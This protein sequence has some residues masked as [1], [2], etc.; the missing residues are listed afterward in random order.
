[1]IIE[2]KKEESPL[3]P[4]LR[5]RLSVACFLT[6]EIATDDLDELSGNDVSTGLTLKN[7][8]LALQPKTNQFPMLRLAADGK[9]FKK[10]M[11]ANFARCVFPPR[12][13]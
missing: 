3:I 1:V 7:F 5:V 9:Y 13:R 2:E 12:E 6:S 11:V 8:R 10:K 4:A